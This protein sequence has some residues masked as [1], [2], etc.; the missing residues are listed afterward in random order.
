MLE[1]DVTK[2][3][4]SEIVLFPPS[5]MVL[6]ATEPFCCLVCDIGTSRKTSHGR[7]G[8]MMQFCSKLKTLAQINDPK[9]QMCPQLIIH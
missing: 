2:K 5:S 8:F 1:K 4:S 9:C 6:A 7:C 3:S